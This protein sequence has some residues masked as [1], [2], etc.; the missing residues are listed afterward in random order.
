MSNYF[1]DFEHQIQIDKIHDRQLSEKD[2]EIERLKEALEL[3]T[4][5][6]GSA[7]ATIENRDAEIERLKA[8]NDSLIEQFKAIRETCYAK[9]ALITELADALE[10]YA[11]MYPGAFKKLIQRARGEAAK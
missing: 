1:Q 2:A 11:T 3:Q 7:A 5:L 8:E 10:V 6:T 4:H 9:D